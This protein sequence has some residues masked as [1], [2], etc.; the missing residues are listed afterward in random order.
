M[1]KSI[2]AE[3]RLKSVFIRLSSAWLLSCIIAF[4]GVALGAELSADDVL[5]NAID[6]LGGESALESVEALEASGKYKGVSGFPG[7]FTLKMKTPDRYRLEWDIG[8]ISHVQAFDGGIA[9]EGNNTPRELVGKDAA[10]IRR[11][12]L[13]FPLL[14][15]ARA[16]LP[17]SANW[18]EDESHVALSVMGPGSRTETFTIDSETFLILSETR[19]EKYEEGFKTVSVAYEDY[20]DVDGVML[21]FV[22]KESR[23]DYSATY[24]V[25]RYTLNGAIE[26]SVFAYPYKDMLDTP[27]A[28]SVSS[29]PKHIYKVSD[30][31]RRPGWVRNWGIPFP[32]TESWTV[33]II[34]DEK[35][36]RFVTPVTAKIEL[37]SGDKLIESRIYSESYLNRLR[38]YPVARFSPESEIY[39]FRHTISVP[40]PASA[41]RLKY[42]F[43]ARTPS[44]EE[45]TTHFETPIAAHR[46]KH[47]YIFP[48]KGRFMITSGHEFY[49]LEHK[50]ERSQQFSMDIV[51]LN[52]NFGL[53]ENDGATID[54]F[55]GFGEREVIA[56][57]DG[58]V[59]YA[60]ND[61]PDGEIKADYLERK[62]GLTAIA[63]NLVVI[64]H[65]EGEYSLFAHMS[66]GSVRVRKGDHVKQSQVLGLMGASG[67]PGHPHLH[68]QL[69][70]GPGVFD[71]DG[72]PVVFENVEQ[73]AWLAGGDN[74]T[75]LKRGIYY[76]AR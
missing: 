76:I 63:G 28:L 62:D 55:F 39:H 53:A 23:P 67:S 75:D 66:H 34:V 24:A 8:Y 38:L 4:Y 36:G 51:A 32:P 5:A 58:E 20:R 44:G 6:A 59:V 14:R 1:F 61:V 71:S 16:G 27:Y 74:V 33:D 2:D 68:Y 37:F 56:P 54:D 10:R 9:W 40:E 70:S 64:D 26:A 60:R 72:L 73:I 52:E 19:Q 15:H 7:V 49:E 3:K 42:I 65:G 50:Y 41:D 29:S 12:A 43:T 48:I 21:P 17:I 46:Q 22:I 31:H 18:S 13:L 69:Q 57:A 45:I 11:A 35:Y 30:N 47:R 25:D